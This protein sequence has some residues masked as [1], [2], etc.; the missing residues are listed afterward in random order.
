VTRVTTSKEWRVAVV[1]CD[2]HAYWF[3]VF[4]DEPDMQVLSTH[5]NE[6]APTRVAVHHHFK[7][8]PAE[9]GRLKIQRV[10]GFRITKVFDRIPEAGLEADGRPKLQYGTYPARARAFSET[11]L[12]HPK[13]CES[14][15][16]LV[17]DVDAGYI[18][19]SSSPKDGADHLELARP[20][21]ERGIPCFVD[22][23]FAATL[24]DAKEMVRLAKANNTVLMNASI[25]AHTDVGKRFRNRFEEIGDV[26]M[27]VVKGCGPSNSGV[28]HGL[29]LAHGMVGY[30]VEWVE[31][32]GSIPLECILLHYA[33]GLEAFVL[34]APDTVFAR[35]HSFCCSAFSRLGV[36]HSPGMS[37]PEFDTGTRRIVELF[38]QMLDTRTPPIPYEHI[39]EPI[40]IIEAARI[41]Q[42]QG[43]RVALKEVL[44]TNGA[45]GRE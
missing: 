35:T 34:S 8:G 26:G 44:E 32:I 5:D 33:N 41:A 9:P 15:E 16:E 11:F 21:L 28:G 4:M 37:D 18:A 2:T 25:L 1:R 23:P 45:P 29:A 6:E 24:A 14:M 40:A 12:S 31:C 39:L 13:V 10:P 19:D 38:K 22:K 20:F 17:E 27:I 3:G 42:K 36:I 7:A 30:G 43:R